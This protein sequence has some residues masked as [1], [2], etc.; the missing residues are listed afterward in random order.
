MITEH[1]TF[2]NSATIV[3]RNL[4]PYTLYHVRIAAHTIARG[5]YSANIEIQTNTASKNYFLV[6]MLV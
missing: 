1:Q 4:N 3:I 5:P 2:G 6:I